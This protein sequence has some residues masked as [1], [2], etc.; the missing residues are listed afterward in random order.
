MMKPLLIFPSICHFNVQRVKVRDKDECVYWPLWSL[1][2]LRCTIDSKG[3]ASCYNITDS[4]YHLSV[5]TQW[6]VIITLMLHFKIIT[7]RLDGHFITRY[8]SEGFVGA[9]EIRLLY[10]NWGL[11]CEWNVTK[12]PQEKYYR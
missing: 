11:R 9:C 8:N 3:V 2:S 7:L 10:R 12:K 4:L 5:D 6:Q 1:G